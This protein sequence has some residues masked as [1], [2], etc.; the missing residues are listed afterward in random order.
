MSEDPSAPVS[1]DNLVMRQDGTGALQVYAIR[2]DQPAGSFVLAKAGDVPT[3]YKPAIG[4]DFFIPPSAGSTSQLVQ[5]MAGFGG[6]SG[7]A[8]SNTAPLGTEAS[9]QPLLTTPQHA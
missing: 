3:T 5:A 7:A 2:N 6:S 1:S 4:S 8:I 9:Q